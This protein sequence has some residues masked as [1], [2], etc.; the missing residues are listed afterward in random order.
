[1][2]FVKLLNPNTQ[3]STLVNVER[4]AS[5]DE[6]WYEG[7]KEDVVKIKLDTGAEFII[8]GDL[9]SAWELLRDTKELHDTDSRA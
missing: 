8:S 1:M 6:C 5:I 7:K 9:Q 2:K 4:I 3:M